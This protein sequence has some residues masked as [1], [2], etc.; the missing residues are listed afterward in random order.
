MKVENAKGKNKRINA[1]SHKHIAAKSAYRLNHHSAT[2]EAMFEALHELQPSKA[3]MDLISPFNN[4]GFIGVHIRNVIPT[5]EKGVDEKSYTDAA[6][7]QM[8]AY[9]RLNDVGNFE[10]EIACILKVNP[11]Q[12]FFLSCDNDQVK[13]K[14]VK[15]FGSKAI[16]SLDN[17]GCDD[18]STQCLRFALA[19]LLLLGKCDM[20]LGSFWSSYS[21]VAGTL[22]GKAVKYAGID[23]PEREGGL[24]NGEGKPG[25][26][27]MYAMAFPTNL[28]GFPR[29]VRSIQKL[30]GPVRLPDDKDTKGGIAL[31]LYYSVL[32][33]KTSSSPTEG[34]TYST[35]LMMDDVPEKKRPAITRI[36]AMANS[37]HEM[38]LYLPRD[39]TLCDDLKEIAPEILGENDLVF[40]MRK[41]QNRDDTIQ[42]SGPILFKNTPEVRRF[43]RKWETILLFDYSSSVT[44]IRVQ[45]REAFEEALKRSPLLKTGTFLPAHYVNLVPYSSP[46]SRALLSFPVTGAV[47]MLTAGWISSE[48]E[49][50]QLCQVANAEPQKKRVLAGIN[51]RGNGTNLAIFYNKDECLAQTKFCAALDDDFWI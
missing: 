33:D 1:E 8:T 40:T 35:Q 25:L 50:P 4:T 51:F 28:E 31:S 43:L 26:D 38:S 30:S 13:N 2:P 47:K 18:R 39:T 45:E 17:N 27:V 20:L 36:R 32:G 19:D 21:E 29:G 24:V 41:H 46:T 34:F 12:K 9:R 42:T 6:L 16:R 15:R 23:F 44:D 7:K 14:L 5:E 48:Y 49:A 3:I 11:E 37:Q 22:T 10:Q